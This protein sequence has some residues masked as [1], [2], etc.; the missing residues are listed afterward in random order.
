MIPEAL[1]TPTQ[2]GE[3]NGGL[4][5]A[6]RHDRYRGVKWAFVAPAVVAVLATTIF[7]L[8]FSLESSF[9]RLS[10][11]AFG[12]PFVGFANYGQLLQS[13]Q[14]I[15]SVLITL[16]I[17]GAAVTC[18]FLLGMAL[19]VAVSQMKRQ[20]LIIALSLIPAFMV[21]LVVGYMWRYMLAAQF[22]VIN[23][24]ISFVIGRPF[25][26]DWLNKTW[27]SYVAILIADM[28]QWTPFMFL[29]LLSG[30]SGIDP[31][32]YDAASIDGCSSWTRFRLITLPLVRVAILIAVTLRTLDTLKIFGSVYSLTAGG[33]G[34]F[35]QT[36]SIL[37][38]RVG[39]N[40]FRIGYAA[41]ATFFVL[42]ISTVVTLGL[43]WLFTRDYHRGYAR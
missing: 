21:P 1:K 18:E 23:Q 40:E 4:G 35:T 27:S 6:A 24:I 32:I 10:P 16:A 31:A 13:H 9:R 30:I 25:L 14:F 19:A 12:K 15:H 20:S 5:G 26:F 33:P 22:G 34:T 38:Y 36:M 3:S 2:I 41:A 17:S 37:I 42:I 43:V 7:P 28:W 11:L 8:L 39:F 29:I